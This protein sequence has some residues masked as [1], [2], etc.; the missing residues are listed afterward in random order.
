M[1]RYDIKKPG[2]GLSDT[3]YIGLDIKSCE[4]LFPAAPI[5][6]TSS[7]LLFIACSVVSFC[8]FFFFSIQLL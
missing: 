7:Q 2:T 3:A 1:Q 4:L 6:V 5:R 8:L